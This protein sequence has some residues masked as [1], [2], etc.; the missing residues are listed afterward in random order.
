[1]NRW[2]WLSLALFLVGFSVATRRVLSLYQMDQDHPGIETVVSFRDVNQLAD[3]AGVPVATVLTAYRQSGLVSAIALEEL[4]LQDLLRDGRISVWRG[5]DLMSLA[6][7]GLIGSW[8]DTSEALLHLSIDSK[9]LYILAETPHLYTHLKTRFKAENPSLITHDHLNLLGV[10]GET[11]DL[12]ET[13][14]GFSSKTRESLIG[15]GFRVIPRL[16]NSVR[17]TPHSLALKLNDLS[18]KNWLRLVIF[19]GPTVVGYPSSIPQLATYLRTNGYQIGLVEFND[20]AGLHALAKQMPHRIVRVHSLSEGEAENERT[21]VIIRRYIRAVS[22]RSVG[23][24]VFKPFLATHFHSKSSQLLPA[25]QLAMA[26]IVRGITQL[27]YSV[28]RQW[29]SL[30]LITPSVL[31][32]VGMGLGVV[33]LWGLLAGFMGWRPWWVLGG[34][35]VGMLLALGPLLL[36]HQMLYWIQVM[37]LLAAIAVPTVLIQVIWM[38]WPMAWDRWFGLGLA[39]RFVLTGGGVMAGGI[40]MMGL[41]SISEYRS[42]FM[43]FVGVKLAFVVPILLVVFAALRQEG[44]QEW[45][46]LKAWGGMPVAWGTLLLGMLVGGGILIY[47]IRSGNDMSGQ[48]SEWERSI[49]QGLETLFGVRPR[50]KEWLIGYPLLGLA[51]FRFPSLR[52]W[53]VGWLA[54]GS[55]ALISGINSFC[56]LHTPVIISIQRG[57][58]GVV[59][60]GGIALLIWVLLVLMTRIPKWVA[61]WM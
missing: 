26:E 6:R 36:A 58:W 28:P 2:M 61:R 11:D 3:R 34:L 56:H 32:W 39:M 27:G 22:E 37:A 24:V 44:G 14:L 19:D 51:A 47:L 52:R 21:D 1:M 18:D 4:T 12:M 42:G 23:V 29:Q 54:L 5:A 40:L 59:L 20:Q 41:M 17:M 13:G 48:V 16:R 35:G 55:V 43:G 31:E 10:L 25:N 8:S 15:Y 9:R 33:G 53:R 30:P 45:K 57:V 7:L 60:G 49:R 38:R 46:R 50:T